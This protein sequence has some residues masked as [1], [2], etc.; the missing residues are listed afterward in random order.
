MK[1]ILLL[2]VGLSAPCFAG[3]SSF[4]E[5]SK[6]NGQFY[7][8][9]FNVSDTAEF[10]IGCGIGTDD[11]GFTIIGLRHPNLYPRYGV[12]DIELSIDGSQKMKIK[13]GS[14]R[15]DDMFYARNPDNEVFRQIF[16]GNL[17]EVLAFNG[18]S[19]ITFSLNGSK[20]VHKELWKRCNLSDY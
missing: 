3:F 2:A 18:K 4:K 12:I 9:Y 5:T 11:K 14:K 8:T 6:A 16:N 20:K 1:K 13:G 19:R 10:H 7:K 15:Y 17:V